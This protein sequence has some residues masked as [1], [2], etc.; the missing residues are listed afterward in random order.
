MGDES[1]QS[2]VR[3]AYLTLG[4]SVVRRRVVVNCCLS[5]GGLGVLSDKLGTTH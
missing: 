2:Q 4:S 1:L 5:P 3:C